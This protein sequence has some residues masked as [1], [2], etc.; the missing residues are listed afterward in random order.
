M[1]RLLRVSTPASDRIEAI[2]SWYEA[3]FGEEM[4]DDF[5]ET[6]LDKF[7]LL[8]KFNEAGPEVPTRPGVRRLVITGRFNYYAF[9][10]L[11]KTEVVILAVTKDY[12]PALED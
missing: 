4:A 11:T 6:I 7:D 2:R 5:N 1:S 9:Y 8:E 12:E 3:N 10:R